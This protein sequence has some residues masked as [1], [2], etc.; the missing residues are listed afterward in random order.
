MKDEERGAEKRITHKH[1]EDTTIK[2]HF[3]SEAVINNNA[4]VKID[5]HLIDLHFVSYVLCPVCL[6]Q[7]LLFCAIA[8]GDF[9][10]LELLSH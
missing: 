4:N 5:T 1:V 10:L 9:Q 2:T 7:R 8:Q 6:T 3:R